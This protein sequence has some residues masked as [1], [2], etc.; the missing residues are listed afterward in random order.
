M[1]VPVALPLTLGAMGKGGEGRA[2]Q[3]NYGGGAHDSPR[4]SRDPWKA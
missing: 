3:S 2:H 1:Q 4:R